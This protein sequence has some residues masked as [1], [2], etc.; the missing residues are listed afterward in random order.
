L[1]IFEERESEVRS[2]CRS[3]PA[4]FEE[5]RNACLYDDTGK[6]YID[7]FA[8]AGA[9][10]YGHNNPYIKEQVLTYLKKDRLIHALDM[11]TTAKAEFLTTFQDL[12][13]KPRNLN[14]KIMCCGSTGT[15]SVEAA[16][17]LARKN[18]KRC[19]VIA[20]SGA[21]HGMSIGS[22]SVSSDRNHRI[23]AGVPLNHVVF[24]PYCSQFGDYRKS[25]EYLEWMLA[26]DHSGVD[27]PACI[28]LETI[29]AEGGVNVAEI[30]WLR[31]VRDICDRYDILMV[32]DDI[33]VGIGRNKTFFSWE[34][35]GIVPDMVTVSKSISGIGFPMSLLLIKPEYDIFTPSEH[36]G[37]FRGFQ[38]SFVGA[39]AGI[40]FFVKN[41]LENKVQEKETVIK[42]YL[43]SQ[44][45]PIS[46]KLEIRGS[47][48]IWGIDFIR[49][50]PSAATKVMSECFENGLIIERAG[51]KDSVLK[52]LPPLTIEK[53][54]LLAG[55]DIIARS[56]RKVTAEYDQTLLL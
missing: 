38:L 34:K 25:L 40:E 22:L 24:A 37:T 56:T 7:F 49:L 52:I 53:E 19:N 47:G 30:E 36:N 33:Q 23:G 21:F 42:E 48:M 16:L 39:K 51:R 44:I 50:D 41:N 8:G 35:S 9:L 3:F 10:N 54:E 4:V 2:Y 5:A 15:N 14:Y 43:E 32:I 28:I 26:D 31:G 6:R 1:T 13:L 12:I 17:K 11:S 29:Q 55:L 27:I 45:R 18:K 20:F 46:S